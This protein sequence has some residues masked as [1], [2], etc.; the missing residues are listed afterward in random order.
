MTFPSAAG[1]GNLPTGNWS[2]VIYSQKVLKGLKK[3]SV[4]EDIT[5]TEF[6]GEIQAFGDTVKIIKEPEIELFDV[7]RGTPTQ[8]QDL[9]DDEVQLVIDQAKGYQFR[10]DDIEK[11]QSHINWATLGVD[12]GAYRFKQTMDNNVMAHMLTLATDTAGTGVSGTER[13]IGFTS[14]D[15]TPVNLITRLA[16]LLDDNDVPDDG[17]RYFVANPEF[18]EILGQED[19]KYI[20]ANTM[21]DPESFIRARKLGSKSI[22]G[23]TC[24]KS[25]NMPLNANSKPIAFAG[26]VAATATAKNILSAERLRSQT[27]FADL[28]RGQ[29]VWGRKVLRPEML[30]VAHLSYNN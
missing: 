19:S 11:R 27:H 16:R 29:Y 23:F 26:H 24:Y 7:A 3:V 5:N 2:P 28:Y 14:S 21:G 4:V 10:V 18:Y 30:F 13:S 22:G 25:T 17:G 12:R 8:T 9:A 6:E 20:E 1:Y 15:M